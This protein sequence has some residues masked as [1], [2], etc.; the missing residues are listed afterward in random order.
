MEHSLQVRVVGQNLRE[1]GGELG[2]SRPAAD[3]PWKEPSPDEPAKSPASP[4]GWIVAYRNVSGNAQS[5]T[6]VAHCL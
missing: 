1:L 2:S 6:A 5:I 3:S 4:G